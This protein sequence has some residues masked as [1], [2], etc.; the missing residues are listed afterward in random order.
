MCRDRVARPDA[1]RSG[2]DGATAADSAVLW[3]AT[4]NLA[5][6]HAATLAPLGHRVRPF[7]SDG[8]DGRDRPQSPDDRTWNEEDAAL[9]IGGRPRSRLARGAAGSE[10][11]P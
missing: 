7:L 5:G 11:L 9:T 2:R 3:A 4:A 1:L 8:Q 6:V 10:M